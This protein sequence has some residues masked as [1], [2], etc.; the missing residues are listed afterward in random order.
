MKKIV[1]TSM[2]I[3]GLISFVIGGF[4]TYAPSIEINST[5]G[6]VTSIT[7]SNHSY[8]VYVECGCWHGGNKSGFK[9]HTTKNY[10]IGDVIKIE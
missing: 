6:I 10:Q 5:K 1:L 4:V 3:G 7:K 8:I 9:L 2:I